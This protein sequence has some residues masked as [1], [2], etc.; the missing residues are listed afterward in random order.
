MSEDAESASSSAYNADVQMAHADENCGDVVKVPSPLRPEVG[1]QLGDE[2]SDDDLYVRDDEP[3]QRSEKIHTHDDDRDEL[4]DHG[5][6][7]DGPNAEFAEPTNDQHPPVEGHICPPSSSPP[8][9]SPPIFF[10]SSQVSRPSSQSSTFVDSMEKMDEDVVEVTVNK[11]ITG[12]VNAE[13]VVD[14]DAKEDV[15]SEDVE[16]VNMEMGE[17]LDESV[18]KKIGEDV[19]SQEKEKVATTVKD[20]V[21]IDDGQGTAEGMDWSAPA[22]MTEAAPVSV[23]PRRVQT[24]CSS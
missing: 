8:S 18:G 1:W 19:A 21:A 17:T 9:S 24:F 16:E 10:S 2:G 6:L 22:M 20:D 14:E 11:D 4:V 15:V 5:T 3:S 23:S 13:V 12:E 7:L